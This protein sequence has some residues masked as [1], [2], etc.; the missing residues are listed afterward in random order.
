MIQK[1]E[2]IPY[3]VSYHELQ[4]V[5]MVIVQ[6]FCKRTNIYILARNLPAHVVQ[7]TLEFWPPLYILIFVTFKYK[8]LSLIR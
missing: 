3:M 8:Q 7:Y 1:Q 5:H 2:F 6:A 4:A